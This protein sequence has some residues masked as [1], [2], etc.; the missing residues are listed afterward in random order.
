[1]QS[2]AILENFPLLG[3]PGQIDDTRE[4][5][6]PNLPY[7]AVYHIADE[8]EIDIIGIIHMAREIP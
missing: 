3:R 5:L 1:L 7:F 2:L 6:I 8:T 4:F